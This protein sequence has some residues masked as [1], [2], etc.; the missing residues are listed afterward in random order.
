MKVLFIYLTTNPLGEE[1]LG[2]ASIASYLKQHNIE[3]ELKL[4]VYDPKN[5]DTE[6]ITKNIPPSDII[7]FPI[8]STNAPIIYDLSKSLKKR[9]PEVLISVGGPL[10]TDA[11]DEILRDCQDI[12]FITLGD[13]EETYLRLSEAIKSNLDIETI[14]HILFRNDKFKVGKTPYVIEIEE[15]PWVS[16]QYLKQ[17]LKRGF[18]TARLT[19]ARGCCANCSF[20]S[21][22]SYTKGTKKIWRGRC[23]TD[24]FDEAVHLY[25]EYGIQSFTFNDGSFEDPGNLG[26]ERIKTF[27]DLVIS[28][29]YHFHFS[30]FLRAD[31]FSVDE[32]QL[33]KRMKEAGFTRV[34]IGIESQN[35]TDLKFY[36]KRATT[37]QNLDSIDL[38]KSCG[39]SVIPGFML[40]NPVSTL[41]SLKENYIFLKDIKLWRPNLFVSKLEIYYK[42][43]M[44]Y[45][46]RELSVLNDNYSYLNPGAY[47]F[48]DDDV[49]MIWEFI[50]DNLIDS[51]VFT[52][53]DRVIY[54]FHNYLCSILPLFPND[55][56]VYF[57]QLHVILSD[58][59]T[60][61]MTYFFDLYYIQ[62]FR[63]A[64]EN[65]PILE[66]NMSDLVL[67]IQS[68]KTKLMLHK[69]IRSFMLQFKL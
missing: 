8:F 27:C 25:K 44:Y 42:T 41:N 39:I 23:I 69:S 36:N 49:A 38:F 16:R 2:T 14:P 54:N 21:H 24:V 65:I 59:S 20:C 18:I 46:C 26:K 60:V 29:G 22:N 68:L 10:A 31:T 40:F 30:A 4:I 1:H 17:V 57:D 32:V 50:E 56:E 43:D 66:Q 5:Y 37:Q 13:G 52:Q 47:R 53:Y 12:D 55:V 61:L 6:N 62:D 58:V 7:G 64:K 28:S 34:F 9:Y 67:K 35:E 63:K 48:I 19:A 15:L 51:I 33:I 45:K 3:A 11:A